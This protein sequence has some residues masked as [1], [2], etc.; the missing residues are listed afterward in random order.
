VEYRQ[1][2]APQS[3]VPRPALEASS[4]NGTNTRI[5]KFRERFSPE[6]NSRRATLNE[7]ATPSTL[8]TKP[9]PRF[10]IL[11]ADISK[12]E[13]FENNSAVKS[14][15]PCHF[16]ISSPISHNRHSDTPNGA[17]K[18]TSM[19]KSPRRVYPPGF[20]VVGRPPRRLH[21]AEVSSPR[22]KPVLPSITSPSKLPKT[23]RLSEERTP[24]PST[25]VSMREF[26]IAELNT[27][28][29]PFS[30]LALMEMEPSCKQPVTG[31]AR[32][33]TSVAPK[34]S[35]FANVKRWFKKTGYF[36]PTH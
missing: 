19:S 27:L 17:S 6:K 8:Y 10:A 29:G 31:V 30:H 13:A 11:R 20:F 9:P 35:I 36:V 21:D 23:G 25:S 14:Y 12:S 18:K 24:R 5:S 4:I 32:R 26:T 2:S 34:R 1:Q 22:Y 3:P 28:G 15:A 7:Q 16:R 33:K